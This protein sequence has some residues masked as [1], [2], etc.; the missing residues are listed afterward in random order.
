MD[1]RQC[2]EN[3]ETSNNSG[4][5]WSSIYDDY[6]KDLK[7]CD[8]FKGQY[9]Y[10]PVENWIKVIWRH[11]RFWKGRKIWLI[12]TLVVLTKYILQWSAVWRRDPKTF[13]GDIFLCRPSVPADWKDE[14]FFFAIS[15]PTLSYSL[16]AVFSWKDTVQTIDHNIQ[17]V[18]RDWME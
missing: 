11:F 17:P 2:W 1:I 9:L 15:N 5:L 18:W 16:L 3:E 8:A 7:P 14:D 10:A 13:P 12:C 6:S 4:R